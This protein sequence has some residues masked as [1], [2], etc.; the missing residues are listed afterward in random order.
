[1]GGQITS[2]FNGRR[3]ERGKE[4]LY[5]RAIISGIGPFEIASAD[6]LPSACGTLG[7]R[8]E[9]VRKM[10]LNEIG[11]VKRLARRVDVAEKG[12]VLFKKSPKCAFFHTAEG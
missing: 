7:T 5:S 8:L 10:G 6:W 2:D 1:M 12:R 3:F 4:F 9:K 11:F